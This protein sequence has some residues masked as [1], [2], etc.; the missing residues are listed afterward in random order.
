VKPDGA[1]LEHHNIAIRG[2]K[3]MKILPTAEVTKKYQALR[4]PVP[5]RTMP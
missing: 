1:V 5:W 4:K 2:K 3:I